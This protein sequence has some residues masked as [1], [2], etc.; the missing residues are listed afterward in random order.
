MTGASAENQEGYRLGARAIECATKLP[1][2]ADCKARTTN[3]NNFQCFIR[4][5]SAYQMSGSRRKR[6]LKTDGRTALSPGGVADA[7]PA[8]QKNVGLALKKNAQSGRF[9]GLK[10]E[11]FC[12]L[13]SDIDGSILRGGPASPLFFG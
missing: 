3:N 8:P 5:R 4:I 11:K 6:F 12:I 9:R 2:P 1:H 7:V 10:Y 13:R